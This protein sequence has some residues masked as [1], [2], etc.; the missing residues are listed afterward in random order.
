M[1]FVNNMPLVVRGD[2]SV[3]HPEIVRAGNGGGGG[4]GFIIYRVIKIFP[5]RGLIGGENGIVN[6]P[7]YVLGGNGGGKGG[8]ILGEIVI[9]HLMLYTGPGE[10]VP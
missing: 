10:K 2:S 6:K 3:I 5:V 7:T 1:I 8:S 4:S 9:P